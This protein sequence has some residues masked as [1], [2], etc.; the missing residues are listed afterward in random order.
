ML[1]PAELRARRGFGA[2]G[3]SVSQG[4]GQPVPKAA[5]EVYPAAGRRVGGPMP[6]QTSLVLPGIAGRGGGSTP[7]QASSFGNRS[8]FD[9]F[10]RKSNVT[11]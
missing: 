11:R 1:Y 8:S 6:P 10:A 7:S 3:E 2:D 9:S 5:T 4:V